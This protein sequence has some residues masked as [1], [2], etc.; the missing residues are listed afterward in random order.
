MTYIG[1]VCFTALA[2]VAPAI[3][4]EDGCQKFAWSVA[5][6]QAWFAAPDKLIVAAG[7]TLATVPKAAFAV[8]LQPAGDAAFALPPERKPRSDRWFGGMLRLP[9]IG[10]AGIYQITL[11]DEAWIDMVQDGRYA[12]SVG[13]SG[14]GDCIGIKKSVRIELDSAPAVFQLSGVASESIL[15]AITAVE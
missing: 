2:L 3:A 15:V 7:D 5:S 10:R 6:E 13:S 4:A 12:R 11:S 8:K 9:A 1:L 14:R